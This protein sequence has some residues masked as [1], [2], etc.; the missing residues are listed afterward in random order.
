VIAENL[1]NKIYFV[2]IIASSALVFLALITFNFFFKFSV[3]TDYRTEILLI[4]LLINLGSNLEALLRISA[5]PEKTYFVALNASMISFFISTFVLHSVYNILML[6][7]FINCSILFFTLKSVE[8]KIHLTFKIIE[9]KSSLKF[10]PIGIHGT[11]NQNILQYG[12]G[13]IGSYNL[14]PYAITIQKFCG[15]LA[16]PINYFIFTKGS[17]I[18]DHPAFIHN[19]DEHFFVYALFFLSAIFF[20]V[21]LYFVSPELII[22]ALFLL[23]GYLVF[24]LKGDNLFIRT[25]NRKYIYTYCLQFILISFLFVINMKI[26]NVSKDFIFILNAFYLFLISKKLR[27]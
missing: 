25:Y 24:S 7:G 2:N 26:L 4:V 6:Q 18:K 27:I 15:L 9:I 13:T 21:W 3:I 5:K 14:I 16:W 17:L 20:T 1:K 11:I 19:N 12:L 8:K 10:F 22:S 23:I